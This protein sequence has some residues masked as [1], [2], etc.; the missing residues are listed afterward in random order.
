MIKEIDDRVKAIEDRLAELGPTLA[1]NGEE[2]DDLGILM[3]TREQKITIKMICN[4][5]SIGWKP[6]LRR[7]MTIVY[8][9]S[10][11]HPHSNWLESILLT[12]YYYMV[13]VLWLTHQIIDPVFG[14]MV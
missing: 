12:I 7:I 13:I 8:G 5:S 9:Q 2:L 6:A 11:L 3:L 4:N 1:D 10:F 14:Y